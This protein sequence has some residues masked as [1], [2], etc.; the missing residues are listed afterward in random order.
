MV[1]IFFLLGWIGGCALAEIV[2]KRK[3]IAEWLKK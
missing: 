1:V 3:A 2:D